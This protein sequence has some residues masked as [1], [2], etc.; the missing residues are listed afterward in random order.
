MHLRY[1]AL[2][3]IAALVAPLATAR[4]QDIAEPDF[5]ASKL[6]NEI[7]LSAEAS[8]TGLAEALQKIQAIKRVAF[9][10]MP[11]GVAPPKPISRRP[12]RVGDLDE[13]DALMLFLVNEQ[14][15]VDAV[16]AVRFTNHDFAENCARVVMEWTFAPFLLNGK[17]APIAIYMPIHLAN[18]DR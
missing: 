7:V 16:Y 11:N 10:Q 13:A 17:P 12:P 8:H 2:T 5:L 6:P 3:L 1:L 9:K 4:D 14:G 18:G 15:K